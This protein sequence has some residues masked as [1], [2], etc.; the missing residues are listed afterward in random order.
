ME[1][2]LNGYPSWLIVRSQT[3]ELIPK[4]KCRNE[5]DDDGLKVREQK[6]RCWSFW[7]FTW[8]K[9]SKL[10]QWKEKKIHW[11]FLFYR[12][13]MSSNKKKRRK[14]LSHEEEDKQSTSKHHM[15]SSKKYL[16]K[17]FWHLSLFGLVTVSYQRTLLVRSHWSEAWSMKWS[18]VFCSFSRF[19]LI[20]VN[21]MLK[22]KL[23]CLSRTEPIAKVD[24]GDCENA[25]WL[26]LAA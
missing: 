7:W 10:L 4:V 26:K 21:V 24:E 18:I 25:C 11:I 16:G 6:F 12:P 17:D 1:E 9:S 2:L 22:R 5:A 20:N 19:C 14:Y 13:A 15:S 8:W 23:V 3:N